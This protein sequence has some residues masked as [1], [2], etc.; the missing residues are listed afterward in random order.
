MDLAIS[1][2]GGG[3]YAPAVESRGHWRSLS[4]APGRKNH[5]HC[6]PARERQYQVK[7]NGRAYFHTQRRPAVGKPPSKGGMFAHLFKMRLDTV[8][9]NKSLRKRAAV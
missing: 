3:G 1:G 2:R 9:L 5:P 7:D 6:A 4:H 8:S